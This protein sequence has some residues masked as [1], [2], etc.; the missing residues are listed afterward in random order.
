MT[1]HLH[2]QRGEH[3]VHELYRFCPAC[4]VE[5]SSRRDHAQ[6]CCWCDTPTLARAPAWRNVP[7]VPSDDVPTFACEPSR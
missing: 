7:S 4:A 2:C 1:G 3:V 6:T 5:S